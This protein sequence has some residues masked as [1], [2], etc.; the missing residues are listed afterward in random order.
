[1][2]AKTGAAIFVL[3]VSEVSVEATR[4][5]Y[6]L[7]PLGIFPGERTIDAVLDFTLMTLESISFTA[8]M[9]ELVLVLQTSNVSVRLTIVI[10]ILLYQSS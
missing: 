1:V 6:R 2:L 8:L 4:S 5:R 10:A 7:A 9:T 3:E